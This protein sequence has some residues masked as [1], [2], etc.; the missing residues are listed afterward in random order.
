[1]PS[2]KSGT[3]EEKLVDSIL[4]HPITVEKEG[5]YTSDIDMK[6]FWELRPLFWTYLPE[7]P[8]G[9]TYE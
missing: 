7:A 9:F 4:H 6:D 8:Q 3:P 2:C 5:F 1:M